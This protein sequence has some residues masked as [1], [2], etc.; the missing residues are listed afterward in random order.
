MRKSA[1]IILL[2]LLTAWTICAAFRVDAWAAPVKPSLAPYDREVYELAYTVFLANNNLEDA[3]TLA[4]A[5]VRQR[6]RDLVWRRRLAQMAS[7]T[8]RPERALEQWLF[9]YEREKSDTA[10]IES[11][12]FARALQMDETL[13]KLYSPRVQ[14]KGSEGLWRDYIEASEHAGSIEEAR[15]SLAAAAARNPEP[16][17]LEQLARLTEQQGD[18][19]QALQYRNLLAEHHG[20]TPQRALEQAR[21]NYTHGDL[22]AGLANLRAARETAKPE[23]TVFW[24]TLG[25]MAWMLQ[26][27]ENVVLSAETL[28]GTPGERSVEL[29]RMVAILKEKKPSEAFS[30][31][32]LGWMKYGSAFFFLNILDIGVSQQSWQ[33]LDMLFRGLTPRQQE[34]LASTPYVWSVRIQTLESL[35]RKPEAAALCREASARFPGSDEFVARLIWILIEL[36]DRPA[37]RDVLANT[38]QADR[39]SQSLRSVYGS[40]FIFLEEY[41]A[42]LPF[43]AAEEMARSGDLVWLAGYADLLDRLGRQQQ[44]REVR[45]HAWGL[46]QQDRK[47]VAALAGN[48][49]LLAAAA[50][51]GLAMAPGDA[52]DSIMSLVIRG[53]QTEGDREMILLWALAS[54]RHDLATVWMKARI[55]SSTPSPPPWVALSL[56]LRNND[57]EAIARLLDGNPADLPI[58]DRVEAARRLG[59]YGES[60]DLAYQGLLQEPEDYELRRQ[61]ADLVILA[62]D[63]G[64]LRTQFESRGYL[65]QLRTAVGGR[66][67]LLPTLQL[68]PLATVV[69]QKSTDQ[70]NLGHIEDSDISGELAVAFLTHGGEVEMGAGWRQAQNSFATF[71]VKGEQKLAADLNLSLLLGVHQQAPE[72]IPLLVAGMKDSIAG[73][74]SWQMTGRDSLTIAA[75]AQLFSDQEG[76][77]LGTGQKIALNYTSRIE[78]ASPGFDFT[79]S[80]T[81]QSFGRDGTPGDSAAEVTPPGQPRDAGFFIPKDYIQMDVGLYSDRSFTRSYIRRWKLFGGAGLSLNNVSGVGYSG[82]IGAVGP[83]FGHDQLL[84][85]LRQG[86]DRFGGSSSSI[87]G[88]FWYTY[89][90]SH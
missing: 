29:E 8:N 66:Y 53:A 31:A 27:E 10:F 21:L 82:E 24:Q 70:G 13:L 42:A 71:R 72:S 17:I 52:A 26:D 87:S 33:T 69:T 15:Q 74:L 11:V 34:L 18:S 81:A 6:P 9:I 57:R 63:K 49:D 76:N 55:G 37:L 78:A 65:D 1:R 12:R 61:Y 32:R 16:Y 54:E 19:R 90:L 44:A 47:S 59:R 7:W 14:K 39:Y 89:Y 60:K 28:Q 23:D 77:R 79:A 45:T 80:L 56:A 35:G 46:V 86:N 25:D 68:K 40:A 85:S 30:V 5:A 4:E 83:L 84:L 41:E 62:A 58:R 2:I 88:E 36:R 67:S 73:Q 51:L 20:I 38:R 50:R 75:D 48:R 22:K 3:F 43:F 64:E